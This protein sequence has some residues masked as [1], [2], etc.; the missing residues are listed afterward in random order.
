MDQINSNCYIHIR[1]LISGAGLALLFKGLNWQLQN[2]AFIAA[3]TLS[4][5]RNFRN[6]AASILKICFS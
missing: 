1:A 4:S 5:F 6:K 2:R 3:P